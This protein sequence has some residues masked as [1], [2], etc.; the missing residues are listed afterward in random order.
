MVVAILFACSPARG[1]AQ[2]ARTTSKLLTAGDVAPEIDIEH[3]LPTAEGKVKPFNKFTNG[4]VYV[5]EFWATWCAPCIRGMPHLA[6]LQQH[7][8]DRDVTIIGVS[9]DP[10]TTVEKFLER[11]V[12]GEGT[13]EEPVTYGELTKK[14][15]LTADP[16]RSVN[17]DYMVAAKQKGIPCAFIVGKDGHIE[18]I[19]N[20]HLGLGEALEQVVSDTWD[21]EAF[22]EELRV[23]QKFELAY[24]GLRG[25]MLDSIKEG[26]VDGAR[27]KYESLIENAPNK[28]LKQRTEMLRRQI[29][30]Y[31]FAC[32]LK[33][34]Q[35]AALDQYDSIIKTR[36]GAPSSYLA[37]GN[38]VSR[39]TLA[40]GE[41]VQEPMHTKATSSLER[42]LR[43][44][45]PEG[46]VRVKVL[47][48]LARL[49][50][51][52]GDLDRAIE[53]QEEA[54]PLAKGRYIKSIGD[55]LKQ[56]KKGK[57]ATVTAE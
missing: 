57:D 17:K 9:S 35:K 41:G 5:I 22:A 14:Y 53:L 47:D 52:R 49:V 10:L 55:H 25:E 36:E 34:D 48:S 38:Y 42:V 30:Y 29:E 15:T 24:E 33:H 3:W 21:R 2:P 44:E 7:Y 32:L 12:P 31:I 6:E 11:K 45:N 1:Q 26:D 8:A 51:Q 27:A 56:L 43:E 20:P 16:D 23:I 18:W 54:L 13:D 39:Y 40:S 50:H 28:Q 37:L 4:H 46:L 19:G